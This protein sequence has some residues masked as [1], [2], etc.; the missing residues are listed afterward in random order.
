MWNPI[1]NLAYL[2]ATVA[3]GCWYL[4][5][6]ILCRVANIMQHLDLSQRLGPALKLGNLRSFS[7]GISPNFL[8][9]LS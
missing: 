8:P 9:K 3:F 4:S 1:S 5:R 7:D 6:E 2:Q